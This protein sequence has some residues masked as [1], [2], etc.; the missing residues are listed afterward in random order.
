MRH[1][2]DELL[3]Q[4]INRG[5]GRVSLE[6][7]DLPSETKI[8]VQDDGERHSS[9]D[10]RELLAV[11]NAGRRDELGTYY[12]VLLGESHAGNSLA[13][14]GMMIDQAELEVSSAFGN[15]LTV[16]RRKPGSQS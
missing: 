7:I 11:L 6:V 14:V 13:M 8:V 5:A 1:I 2:L 9:A 12:G 16:H 4:A 15:R 10:Q 3:Q